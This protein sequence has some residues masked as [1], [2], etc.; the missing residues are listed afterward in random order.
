[1]RD[2][3]LAGSSFTLNQHRREPLERN[4]GTC[5]QARQLVAHDRQ[6]RTRTK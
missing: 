6:R 4:R 2:E 5:E 1:M 3:T